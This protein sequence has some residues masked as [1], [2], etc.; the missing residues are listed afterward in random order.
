MSYCIIINN[1]YDCQSSRLSD[2]RAGWST[3]WVVI[4]VAGE[5]EWF[6]QA[7]STELNENGFFKWVEWRRLFRPGFMG[8]AFSNGLN[9]D[10]LFDWVE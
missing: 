2:Q 4:A 5:R 9:E 6:T 7:F 10:G 3:H 1:V 8:T